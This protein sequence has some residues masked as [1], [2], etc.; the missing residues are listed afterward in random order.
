MQNAFHA[1]CALWTEIALSSGWVEVLAGADTM[2]VGEAAQ[3]T[4]IKTFGVANSY[5]K[6]WMGPYFCNKLKEYLVRM[7]TAAD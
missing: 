5:W 7:P 3:L 1:S 6:S 4:K 2:G